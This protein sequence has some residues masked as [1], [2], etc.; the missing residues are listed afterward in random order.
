MHVHSDVANKLHL[1][2]RID[3]IAPL[4]LY[5]PARLISARFA[6]RECEFI[7]RIMFESAAIH[8][9]SPRL[10]EF[11]SFGEFRANIAKYRRIK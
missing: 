7:F 5:I 10:P 2:V 1:F 3:G 4:P 6:S 11:E 8:L 9:T